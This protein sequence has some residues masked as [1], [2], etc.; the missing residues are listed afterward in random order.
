MELEEMKQVWSE[1]SLQ[2]EKQK[3]L[4]DKLIIDMTRGKYKSSLSNIRASEITGSVICLGQA[5]LIIINL[6]KF[7]TGFL[8]VCAIVSAI[9]LIVLPIISI[10]AIGQLSNLN[11]TKSDFKQVLTD[12]A[13]EKQRFLALKK[14]DFYLSSILLIV[15]LPVMVKLM[16][17]KNMVMES[18]VWLWYLPFG[19][20]FFAFFARWVYK[21]YVKVTVRTEDLL[22][23]LN[24]L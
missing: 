24:D 17:G 1:M 12:Y 11:I 16:D 22:K 19:F 8:L 20:L 4:T 14:L 7:D 3:K 23:E 13:N 5:L 2:I 6:E 21:H 9:I 10:R 18:N 15:I